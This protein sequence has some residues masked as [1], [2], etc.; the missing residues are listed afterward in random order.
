MNYLLGTDFEPFRNKTLT[1]MRPGSSSSLR[2]DSRV[3]CGRRAPSPSV[4]QASCSSSSLHAPAGVPI[5]QPFSLRLPP[6]PPRHRTTGRRPAPVSCPSCWP[7]SG[8]DCRPIG[9][10]RPVCVYG[11][12]TKNR[13]VELCLFYSRVIRFRT[14]VIVLLF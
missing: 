10:H 5:A 11:G 1:S 7:R 13:L 3:P 6:R 8:A 4:A 14:N 2:E 12:T 9:H